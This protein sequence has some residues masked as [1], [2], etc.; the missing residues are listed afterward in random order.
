MGMVSV[1]RAV[2]AGIT[3]DRHT[4]EILVDPDKAMEF[5]K[6]RPV[7]I[8][9]IL[10]VS[11][12][13]T[14]ARK[15]DRAAAADLEKAF[16]TGD[17]FAVAEQI[18]RHGHIQFTTEQRRKLLEQKEKE[19]A[20]IISR[21]G[22]NPQTNIPHPPARIR[23]A[24]AEARVNLDPFLPASQQVEPVL[25]KIRPILP[26]RIERVEVAIRIPLQHA[27]RASSILHTLAV[28]KKE[29]WGADAF[30]AVIEIPAGMQAEIYSRLNELTAGH[31]DVKKLA[32]A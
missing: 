9:H 22:I 27:G 7:S 29:E 19:V 10:A 25:E 12:I 28:V 26:I 23:N 4:F 20:E 3:R 21:Q 6:G 8:E 17:L 15:G 2:I 30:Y 16:H 31:V 24:M 13:F 5:R 11:T 18:L 14:D 32:K 1:D